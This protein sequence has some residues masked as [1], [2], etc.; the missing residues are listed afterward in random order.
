MPRFAPECTKGYCSIE[1]SKKWRARSV[2]KYQL[3][4]FPENVYGQENLDGEDGG[5][6]LRED[7]LEGQ[8]EGGV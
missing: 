3:K 1:W 7:D 5:I 4:G 2:A 6:G 8:E